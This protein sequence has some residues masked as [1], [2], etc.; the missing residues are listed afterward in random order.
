M[1]RLVSNIFNNGICDLVC[2][3][4]SRFGG[5]ECKAFVK[6]QDSGIFSAT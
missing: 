4:E 3:E 2:S 6:S 1:D 5:V